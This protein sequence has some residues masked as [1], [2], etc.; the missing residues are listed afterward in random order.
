MKK[1]YSSIET[2]QEYFQNP[3]IDQSGLKKLLLGPQAFTDDRESKL[4]FE[5]KE[6]FV[7]GSMVDCMLTNQE[8]DFDKLYYV[9]T[10]RN[11]PSDTIMSI[12]NQVFDYTRANTKDIEAWKKMSL[13]DF[14][15]EILGFCTSHE[16]G[17][18]YKEETRLNKVVA[19]SEYYESLKDGIGKQVVSMEEYSI[20]Q[21]IVQSLKTTPILK[22]LYDKLKDGEYPNYEV[23]FQYP[24]YFEIEGEKCKGLLDILIINTELKLAYIIDVK[25]TAKRTIDFPESVNK[26]RYDIQLAFYKK[27]I[28]KIFKDY[29][30]SC[31]LAVESTTSIGTPMG[32]KL[33]EELLER[34]KSGLSPVYVEDRLIRQE[35]KGYMQ[36]L[37]DYRFYVKH[38]FVDDRR[39]VENSFKGVLKLGINGI[40]KNED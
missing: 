8:G 10:I 29:E 7:I 32:Y 1:F 17:A 13:I 36:L 31:F 2:I 11:K 6:S 5:E 12:I 27:G 4:Y 16:Y 23:C 33:V 30:I 34:G 37:D 20:A 26:F 15:V 38:G 18:S 9:S 14:P 24:V 3:A 22:P 19:F 40:I 21:N 39:W 35:V 28:S 25:T